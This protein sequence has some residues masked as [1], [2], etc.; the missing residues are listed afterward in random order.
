VPDLGQ[1]PINV[2]EG[3]VPYGG[4]TTR[5]IWQWHNTTSFCN[6]SVDL[7]VTEG[8]GMDAEREER[9]RE[10]NAWARLTYNLHAGDATLRVR[11]AGSSADPY[12]AVEFTDTA[13]NPLGI[14]VPTV[15]KPWWWD[16]SPWL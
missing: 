1:T 11:P 6:H 4:W 9:L 2:N 13:G 3:F 14:K 5:T 12:D 15:T 10:T 7:N 8:D 16:S